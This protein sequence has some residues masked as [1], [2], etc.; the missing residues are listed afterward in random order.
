MRLTT[1]ILLATLL[2]VSAT[3]FG[4]KVTLRQNAISLNQVFNIL[5]KQTG[6]T[7]MYTTES[8]NDELKINTNFNETP[9][10][11]AIKTIIKDLPISYTIKGKAIVLQRVEKNILE[12]IVNVFSNIDVSGRLVD[13]DGNPISGATITVKG[14]NRT[15]LSGSTG[16]FSLSNVDE[17]N[18][19]TISYVGYVALEIP[20]Q[21]NLGNIVLNA[22][23]SKLEEVEINAGYYTVTDRG[24]TGNIIKI[25]STTIEKQ[26]I[27]NPLQAL[28]NR[29]PG[30]QITQTTGVAGGGFNVLIRGRSSINT[31]VGNN[32]LYI[33]DDVIYP[34][35][36][37]G[38]N[39]QANAFGIARID[40]LSTINPNDIE[41]IEILK[42]ADATA[43]Y[44]SRGAN[45]IILIKTKRGKAGDI[46]INGVF[47]QGFSQVAKKV[48]LLKTSEYIE[49]R[50]EAL[51]NDGLSPSTIDYDI[52]GN[53]DK[54]KYTDWQKEIIGGT[55]NTSVASLNIS[56]GNDKVNYLIGGNYYNEGTVLPGNFGFSRI[57]LRSNINFGS[58]KDRVNL[59]FTSTYNHTTNSQLGFDPT[60]NILL[61]PN[62]PDPYN[63]YGQLN[64]ANNTVYANPMASF[65]N[66]NKIGI[67]NM[68][69]NA[70][71]SYRLLDNLSFKI[72]SGYNLLKY[73]D[74]IKNSFASISPARN[75]TSASRRSSFSNSSI[76][77]WTA[78]PQLNFKTKI[79]LGHL[80]ALAG[81]SFQESINQSRGLDATNFASDELLDNILSAGSITASAATYTQY[82]YSAV[83][84]RINYSL[85]DKLFVNLTARRDGSTRFGKDKQF[86]NF[87]AIGAAYLFSEERFIKNALP[88]ISLGKIRASYGVTGNDQI[89]DY[90]Y[91][92]L[93]TSS[94]IYQ[95]TSTL[96]PTL[97]NA[98]YGW[99]TNKKGEIALQLNL[100][101]YKVNFEISYYNNRSSNQLI[102]DPLPPSTGNGTII[103]NRP[104]TVQNTGLEF[105]TN[106]N[107]IKN[108]NWRWTSGINLTI[109]KNKLLSY[110]GIEN[111]ADAVN[112]VVGQ[113]LSIVRIYNSKGV[114]RQTGLYEF[115]DKNNNGTNLFDDGDRYL[116]KFI[117][118]YFYGGFQNS[119]RY[120]NLTLDFLISFT[121]QN[122]FNYL[123]SIQS[124][125][126]N[127]SANSYPASNQ[128][129]AALDR[130]RQAGDNSSAQKFSTSLD[131]DDAFY[132][133]IIYGGLNVS[134]A[135]YARLKNLSLSYAIPNEWL[136]KSHISN[137]SISIT[138]QNVFTITNY[139]GLDPETMDLRRLPPLRTF[140]MSINLTF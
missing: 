78:E 133:A 68:I 111:S 102:G 38:G 14:T 87:G 65:L 27:L 73:E 40:P 94:G 79:G 91:L 140:A 35:T 123:N 28:Q 67:D 104:A 99:E 95:N 3:T 2:Q 76:N 108:K 29:I 138:G 32:P 54:N 92:Q 89:G 60:A 4:Q 100:F 125:P 98:D 119:L 80:D 11:E 135:S 131:A 114:S 39:N 132:N 139:I 51:K 103:A 30:I 77:S 84:S 88:F 96:S 122:G 23:D 36:A 26:P 81:L 18:I 50:M 16:F 86:A 48:N 75:P 43:I 8:L 113:P 110:P 101:K 63:Q 53:W 93:Y 13:K 126:G 136:A 109:P 118:Q 7:V 1:V 129:T 47:T 37:L 22:A 12:K 124:V 20:V 82:R 42:D 74:F 83:F 120:K 62:Q 41:S 52:N 25:T 55:A 106:F 127:W 21:K 31:Q 137:A 34:S 72:S 90:K 105:A 19:L 46:K 116:Q 24:R 69:V 58:F 9:L 134:D 85:A 128:P 56:G 64:W 15:V 45:G 10:E 33:I 115:E 112:F 17:K 66:S 44:G 117:G 5:E 6:Y 121:K 97:G 130:W 49:M 61:A 71:L 107:L 57:G 70:T 59:N